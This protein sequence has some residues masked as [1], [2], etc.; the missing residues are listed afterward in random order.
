[1]PWDLIMAFWVT[2]RKGNHAQDRLKSHI[3]CQVSTTE[4][5]LPLPDMTTVEICGLEC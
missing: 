1:M 2:C 3:I 5:K 4:S